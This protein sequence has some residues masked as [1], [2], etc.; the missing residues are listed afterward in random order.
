LPYGVCVIPEFKA[1]SQTTAYY[2]S[3]SPAVG[4]PGCYFV[5][6]YNLRARPK[7]EMEGAVA[8]RSGAGASFAA[9]FGERD[10]NVP[11]FR[12]HAGYSAL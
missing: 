8:A 6:T 4:R 3:G 5:N 10:E 1:P 7:W 11:E 2:Q 9:V 12:K